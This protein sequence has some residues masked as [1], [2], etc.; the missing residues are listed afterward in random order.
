VLVSVLCEKERAPRYDIARTTALG[1]VRHN[2]AVRDF[3]PP[4][5]DQLEQFAKLVDGS[6][7]GT[8]MI[9]HCESG[10]GRAGTFAAAYWITKG[11][12]AADAITRVREVRWRA[13]E[14]PEQEAVLVE[15]ANRIRRRS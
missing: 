2:I 7:P 11:M 15:F 5:V 3:C 12:T 6:P 9:V 14:T 10:T 1:Y 13:V 8:K 4:S